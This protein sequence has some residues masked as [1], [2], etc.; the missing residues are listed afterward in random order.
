MSL[1]IERVDTGNLPPRILDEVRALCDEAYGV[2]L[3]QYFGDIGP[4]IHPL[5]WSGSTLVSHLMWVERVLHPE[6]GNPLRS[7]YVELVATRISEQGRGFATELMKRLAHE[8]GSYDAGALSPADTSLYQR[9]GWQRWPGP[10][11]VRTARGVEAT[12]DEEVMVLCPPG[13]AALDLAAPLS[14]DWPPVEVW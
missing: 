4:G 6:G 10:L 1:T 11:F 3:A 5:G 7:A 13:S 8:I 12:P 14:V 9:L 2:D